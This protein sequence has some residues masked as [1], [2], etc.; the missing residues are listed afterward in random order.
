MIITPT[1][2]HPTPSPPTKMMPTL[3]KLIMIH[4][5]WLFLE[6]WKGC[7]YGT[8]AYICRISNWCPSERRSV[9]VFLV[10]TGLSTDSHVHYGFSLF[11]QTWSLP[12]YLW[13]CSYATHFSSMCFLKGMSPG[14]FN[15]NRQS[16]RKG[17]MSSWLDKSNGS[18]CSGGELEFIGIVGAM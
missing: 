17:R 14:L 5:Q 11:T 2:P 6:T 8:H 4:I 12:E 18:E 10:C 15:L 16:L 1:H 7:I 9:G 13:W 3:V